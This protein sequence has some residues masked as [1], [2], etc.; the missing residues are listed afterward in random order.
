MSNNVAKSDP[1]HTDA[2]ICYNANYPFECERDA[3]KVFLDQ[4]VLNIGNQK[5]AGIGKITN[6]AQGSRTSLGVEIEAMG[7]NR[8]FI[9]KRR[10][11][12]GTSSQ[13]EAGKRE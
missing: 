13:N 7:R 4:F 11:S 5:V 2:G 9:G 6:H 1:R 8:E 12:K 3:R 10:V